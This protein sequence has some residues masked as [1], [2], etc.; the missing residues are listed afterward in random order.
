MLVV[1]ISVVFAVVAP[2]VL[3]PCALFCLFSR[4]IWTHHHL[5]VYE[6]VFETGGQFWPKIFR[7]FVFGLIIAQMTITGQFILKEARHEAYA[8]IALILMTYVFL[9][10][11]RAR[12]DPSS[13][14]LPLEVA[15]VMDITLSQEE[16]A[17]RRARENEPASSTARDTS[18]RRTQTTTAS[19]PESN[20]FEQDAIDQNLGTRIGNVDPFKY[21]YLQPALR[22]NPRARPEQPFPPGQLGREEVLMGNAPSRNSMSGRSEDD[23]CHAGASVRLK[24]LNQQDRR[25]INRWWNDQLQ[26][27]GEQNILAVLIGE[28]SGTLMLGRTSVLVEMNSRGEFA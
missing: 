22:A 23:Y 15:T 18:E 7:R 9:R 21:A 2:L 5:Y 17:Q 10:S 16:E 4:I 6:S 8:T 1:V 3:L 27:C 11:T 20:E 28:E 26:S 12:Y 19:I 14:T 25:L 24:S 13:S